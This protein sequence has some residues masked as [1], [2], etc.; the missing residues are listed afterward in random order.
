[1]DLADKSDI[2]Y[3]RMFRRV[4]YAD[5]LHQ[6]N[7]LLESQANF[8]EAEEMQKKLQPEFELLY[9]KQGF[10][11]CDLLLSQGNYEAV[12][13]RARQTLE[14]YKRS[15]G[16]SLLAVALDILSLG[17]AQ[18]LHFQQ[19]PDFAI[20][21]LRTIFNRAVDGLRQ[22]ATQHHIPHGLLTRAEYYLVTGDLNKAQRDLDEAFTIATRGGMGLHL[23]DCHLEYARLYVAKG[24]KP[25]A[26]EH[27]QIA[28]D[29]IEKMGYHRRDKEV[30]ELEEQLK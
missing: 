21:D 13:R 19:D 17:R 11:Y 26:R 16:I 1:M 6:A 3:Q 18:L 14:Y 8:H 20:T 28:K 12:E 23:A 27:W 4:R 2:A 29:S 30:Q 15:S 24:D 25:K 7:R 5:C 10:E 22:A 9:A